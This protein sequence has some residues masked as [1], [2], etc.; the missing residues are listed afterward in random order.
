MD[1]SRF[2][3]L[4]RAVATRQSRRAVIVALGGATLS[5]AIA[6]LGRGGDAAARCR[7]GGEIC[8]TNGEC[9]SNTCL[10]TDRT[11][12]RVCACEKGTTTCGSTCCSAG[13]PCLN[14][15]CR[16]STATRT[17]TST[18]TSTPTDTPTSTATSTPTDTATVTETS[19]PTDT[20]T[21]TATATETSTPTDTPT[22][23]ATVTETSTPTDTAT[24]TETSTPVSDC[25]NLN[26]CSGHG[27][28]QP[29]G[30]CL[31]DDPYIGVA[32]SDLPV[33]PCTD[34]STCDACQGS[35][36]GC[37]WCDLSTTDAVD[38]CTPIADC[39]IIHPSCDG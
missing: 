22:D 4:T 20:P 15:V 36:Q 1:G 2:D 26:F 11:G 3:S 21:D 27:T 12:R 8:A 10:S 30:T 39:V 13:M 17:A 32:C 23:T 29:D 35:N 5:G 31:C 6:F 34:L 33:V 9:C 28:C 16:A 18:P 14:G 7:A 37:V 19:T 25:R 38:V 24:P